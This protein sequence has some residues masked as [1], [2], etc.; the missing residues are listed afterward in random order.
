[1]IAGVRGRLTAKTGERVF[2]ATAGGVTYEIAVPVGVLERLPG[3]G[4]DVELRTVPVVREDGWFLY[5]FDTEHERTV[6]QRLLGATGVGPKLAM[7]LLS[8]LGGVRTVQA[9]KQGELGLLC[10]VPGIGKKT[11]ERMVL[12]LKDKFGDLEAPVGAPPS[13]MAAEQALQALIN[14]GYN[15]AEADRAVRAVVSHNG[16]EETVELIRGAL[17]RLAAR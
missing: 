11:A 8:A 12:E 4:G 6:F 5:G 16:A 3:E 7:A 9:L 10:T 17:Q 13:S 15:P 1:M 2:V 14:L